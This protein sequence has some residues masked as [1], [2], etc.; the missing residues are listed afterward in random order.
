MANAV[1]FHPAAGLTPTAVDLIV[2][3]LSADRDLTDPAGPTGGFCARA[4]LIGSTA[5]NLVI[6]TLA[7]TARTVPVAANQLVE[8][9]VKKVYSTGNGTTAAVV[10][11]VL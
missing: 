9:C 1:A 7:G 11:A 8:G 5:G 10:I 2:L 6:D 3:D 4:I